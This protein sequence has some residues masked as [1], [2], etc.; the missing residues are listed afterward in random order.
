[1]A[2]YA[3]PYDSTASSAANLVVDERHALADYPNKWGSVIPKFAPFYRKDLVVRHRPSGRTLLEGIDYYLGHRFAEASTANK[4]PVYGSIMLLDRSLAGE[5][6]FKQYR[7]LGGPHTIPFEE[8]LN[9]LAREDNPDPRNADWVDVMKF[10]RMVPVIVA[11]DDINGAIRDDAITGK[12]DKLAATLRQL[13]EQERQAYENVMASIAALGDKIHTFDVA[14]HED[15]TYPHAVTYTQLNAIKKDGTAVDALKAYGL[16]LA[17]FVAFVESAAIEISDKERLA[18][19]IGD[20]LQG[21][22]R[23][24]G[25][26]CVIQGQGGASTLD[27]KTG[28][29]ALV[30]TGNVTL[31]SNGTEDK[32][33]IGLQSG[34]NSLSL[35]RSYSHDVTDP[36]VYNG[37][38]VIHAG[39]IADY[40][41]DQGS[42]S[43]QVYTGAGDHITLRGIGTPSRP[44]TGDVSFP[45]ATATADGLFSLSTSTVSNDTDKAATPSALKAIH[46]L[47]ATLVPTSRM[48][49]GRALTGNLT[50]SKTDFGLGR[51]DNTH[52]NSKP[53][54]NAFKTAAAAKPA[55]D[56]TH[57]LADL[58]GLEAAGPE[59]RGLVKLATD[60][61]S[62]TDSV[63]TTAVAAG[64]DD[65]TEAV[66]NDLF[67]TIPSE[68]FDIQKYGD[69]SYLPIPARGSYPAAGV[70]I[71]NYAVVGEFE[72]GGRLV[73][74]RNGADVIDSGVYYSYGDLDGSGGFSRFINTAAEYRPRYL[75]FG[76]RVLAASRGSAGVFI[77]K[78]SDGNAHLVLT[79][80]T[81][82]GEHHVGSPLLGE[83]WMNWNTIP[84]IA[85]EYVYIL[86]QEVGR[87][88]G[89]SV[90]LWRVSVSDVERGVALAPA[91][92]KLSGIDIYGDAFAN[93]DIAPLSRVNVSSNISDK[94]YALREDNGT[95]TTVMPV[96]S[97]NNYDIAIREDEV[98]VFNYTTVYL[99]N[100]T[101]SR[102]HRV[103][104]SYRVDFK[105]GV[106]NLDDRS[107][108]PIKIKPTGAETTAIAPSGEWA[109]MP[110]GNVDRLAGV[111]DAGDRMCAVAYHRTYMIPKVVP[112]SKNDGTVSK[113]DH[114]SAAT[115][116]ITFSYSNEV[117]LAGARG[118]VA[119]SVPMSVGFL[120]DNKIIARERAGTSNIL[121][122]DPS[123]EYVTG[124]GGFGPTAD[125]RLT[126]T[127]GHYDMVV[128]A[129]VVDLNGSVRNAGG[130]FH[131]SRLSTATVC[132]NEQ[133]QNVL[134]MSLAVHD[135]ANATVL[136]MLPDLVEG[137]I[138]D[139]TFTL[140][141]FG[142]YTIAND[143]D[144]FIVM[145]CQHQQP[146][147]PGKS[148]SLLVFPAQLT[149]ANG[150]ITSISVGTVLLN[151]VI[152]DTST[153]VREVALWGMN[154][155]VKHSDT[156]TMFIINTTPPV[157]VVGG[158]AARS[159]VLRRTG[160]SWEA[161]FVGI[162]AHLTSSWHY[163][164]KLGYFE[165]SSD[166]SGEAIIA[167]TKDL[168]NLNTTTVTKHIIHSTRVASGWIVY[169][170][171]PVPFYANG[172]LTYAPV[173]SFDLRE[174]FPNAYQSKTF[175]IYVTPGLEIDN[176]GVVEVIPPEYRFLTDHIDD[177]DEMLYIGYCKTDDRQITELQVDSVLRMGKLREVEEHIHNPNG[178]GTVLTITKEKFG[179]G[180]LQNMPMLSTLTMPTF[181]EVF[182]S[183]KRFVHWHT[184]DTQPAAT[185]PLSAW[186]YLEDQDVLRSMADSVTQHMFVGFISPQPVGDYTFDVKV[187][188]VDADDDWIG[189][190]LAYAVDANG[191]E[192]TLS[193][194]R[195]TGAEWQE[196][197]SGQFYN[198]AVVKNW[199]QPRQGQ[200]VLSTAKPGKDGGWGGKGTARIRAVRKADRITVTYYEFSVR[201][202]DTV[203]HEY[204]ID[205]NEPDLQIFK[206]AANFGFCSQ[207]QGLATFDSSIRPDEDV[208]N[209]Y[210]TGEL[211]RLAA[212]HQ[213]TSVAFRQGLVTAGQ[214]VPVPPGF[215]IAECKVLVDYH[216]N[217]EPTLVKTQI[218]VSCDPATLV[219]KLEYHNGSTWVT[220]AGIVKYYLVARKA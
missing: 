143:L 148:L 79:R 205:L 72:V 18:D 169:F 26:T 151:D 181:K 4:M 15:R 189:I 37:F 202:A 201:N 24:E 54:S 40:V 110:Y 6:E 118:S 66:E 10:P 157:H 178:H 93:V 83:W 219:T 53:A 12:L 94:P 197:I 158:T 136:N 207:S 47:L 125:R 104:Y 216:S 63:I 176:G 108:F 27:L 139:T 76:V 103:S 55:V 142:D 186:E 127:T 203:I 13:A 115:K 212:E 180:H 105:T 3:Y 51:V 111:I 173:K 163:H 28:D 69:A 56:H 109:A 137:Q 112:F 29:L 107:A 194:L 133:L 95:W 217:S 38:Y 75:P 177:S 17:Q 101:E 33:A 192:H 218:K 64:L 135:A 34:Q 166:D 162:N 120:S 88:L 152:A 190:V 32:T 187:S 20:Q 132:V 122:Y 71:S 138:L 220:N 144:A 65:R 92:V 78:M 36:L 213:A 89:L 48:V 91:A 1:M 113:F 185:G 90:R 210:A 106:V 60:I 14:V 99:R 9:Y 97:L 188:S 82:D 117:D 59:S 49:N 116:R 204:V 86:H 96:R 198:C 196:V 11:P 175:Y 146:S 58:E 182:D 81:M 129:N 25:D 154:H 124:D 80:G 200:R 23:L 46:D 41:P 164:P 206:G 141:V 22:L 87:G 50:F 184:T 43:Q 130:V 30:A 172:E 121:Q 2:D 52:P 195:S 193:A 150:Q 68:A 62:A 159:A 74:L 19:L 21:R 209:Y 145:G 179:A 73:L 70:N 147:K 183:W 211:V 134:S 31:T 149:I 165:I 131:T 44:L 45:I 102:H 156:E 16:T 123:G 98:R 155:R 5:V 42:S 61:S 85:G 100:A 199:R 119:G 171:E 8:A 67:E 140:V 161:K 174:L 57:T 126:T 77:A 128:V 208:G 215:T 7:T 84:F 214:A 191:R 160:T 39:N 168:R 153:V 114:L 167:N 35:H 170:T